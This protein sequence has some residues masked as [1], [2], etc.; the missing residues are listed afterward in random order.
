MSNDR[1][2]FTSRWPRLLVHLALG[3]LA[4]AGLLLLQLWPDL[5]STWRRLALVV[6]L[7]PPLY[8]FA[9]GTFGW[10]VSPKHGAAISRQRFSAVRIGIALLLAFAWFAV[11]WWF[12]S[13]I[14]S[15][16]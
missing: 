6:G 11:A 16:A 9:E 1:S 3:W 4:L 8:V 10:L 2:S 12:A 14:G 7:G 13:F 15:P 5:P